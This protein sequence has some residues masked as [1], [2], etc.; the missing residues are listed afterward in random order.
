MYEQSKAA[1][2]KSFNSCSASIGSLIAAV[3][4]LR[5]FLDFKSGPSL[6]IAEAKLYS[7]LSL[8]CRL[9]IAIFGCAGSS[10]TGK[11]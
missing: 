3:I 4:G 7:K 10:F 1:V 8:Y 2:L 5:A 11:A 6:L 9:M